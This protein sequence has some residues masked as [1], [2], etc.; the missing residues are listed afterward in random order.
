MASLGVRYGGWASTNPRLATSDVLVFPSHAHAF[1]RAERRE[2]LVGT[3][4]GA[5][6][7]SSPEPLGEE[8]VVEVATVGIDV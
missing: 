4:P 5:G 2:D 8:Q 7:E 6:D 3:Q 1:S